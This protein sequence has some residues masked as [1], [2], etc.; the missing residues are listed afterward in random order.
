MESPG[1]YT[2]ERDK[3]FSINSIESS[4]SAM[5]GLFRWGPVNVPT[6]ITTNEQEL[7]D[8]FGA[9]DAD[10]S[11]SFHSAANYLL[12]VT[13]L[14][15]TRAIDKATA[16]NAVPAG[17][18]PVYIGNE[19]IYENTDLT[20]ISFLGRYPGTLGN[21]IKVSCADNSDYSN[22]AY[23]GEFIYT[24]E[25]GE[26]NM[27]VVDETGEITGTAGTILERY[28]LMSTTAGA[29]KPD[30]SS[31]YITKV[32]QNQSNWVYCG[33]ES[34]IDFTAS[35][36]LGVYEA[37]L[38]GGVDGN[39]LQS[40]DFDTA[41]AELNDSEALDIIS[42]F[43]SNM[44]S[45]SVGTL[46]NAMQ[47]RQDAVAFL[48]PTLA[49]VYNNQTVTDDVVY[50][51]NTTINKNHS[52][53]FYVDNWKLVYDRYNDKN[54]WIPCDSDAAALNSRVYVQ[55][56]PWFSP[57][58]LNRGQLKNVIRLAWSANKQQRDI[59]YKESINSIVA[60]DGEGTVLWGDKTA[61]KRPSA[62]SRVNVRNLFIVL[63]KSIARASKYQL[64]ELNDEITRSIFRNAVNR[65]LENVKGRR[66]VYRYRVIADST[67]NTPQVINTNQF[68]G[69]IYVDP[70]RSINT[71]KL[72]FIAVDSGVDFE[73]VEGV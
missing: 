43:A 32:L 42:V 70:A 7:V 58:G 31:A 25:A 44:P 13:P 38:Q 50:Y 36:S 55:N 71:I 26:F 11:V 49:D 53:A 4:A 34:A 45:A 72:N 6:R 40:A 41:I 24:P 10:T 30:G 56:E 65:Y 68:V 57:A 16:L 35:D 17:E 39:S 51:F 67:N 18:I 64:F 62:F 66:G 12:Y 19:G 21:A 9:P 20:G 22:W 60:F 61:L 46:I 1:V 23:A 47:V 15:V 14:Y 5:V 8:K 33:D 28:E 59:L 63:K 27:V 48:A 52:Y 2:F 73:E 37:S 54:I 29:K 3:T 69:D